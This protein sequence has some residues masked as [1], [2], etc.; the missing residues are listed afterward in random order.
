MLGRTIEARRVVMVGDNLA[1]DIAGGRSMGYRTVLL[2]SGVTP[3]EALDRAEP[4]NR[5]DFVFDRL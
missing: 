1:A 5:P 3:A 2:L 4:G